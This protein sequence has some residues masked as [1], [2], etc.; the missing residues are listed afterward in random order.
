MASDSDNRVLLTGATGFIGQAV[1][2]LLLAQGA[3]VLALTTDP[4][5]VRDRWG[6]ES[7]DVIN[8]TESA[9]RE[10]VGLFRP[11]ILVHLAWSALP[12][13]SPLACLRNVESTA[14]VIRT[15]L[16]SGVSRFLGA[17]SCWE[18][19]DRTGRLEE[20]MAT[21]PTTM[22][23]QA[24]AC[25]RELMAT[26]ASDTGTE[27]RWGRIFY[28]YGTGQRKTSL[29]PMTIRAWQEGAAPELR[30]TQSAIDLI[31][32][33]DVASGLVAMALQ[34]GPSGTF[35]LGSGHAT[36]VADVVEIVS[37]IVSGEELTPSLTASTDKEASWADISKMN[38]AFGW[39]P[40]ITLSDG[41]RM[42]LDEGAKR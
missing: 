7:V 4:K 17:G 36:R 26:T 23:A 31:H 11:S 22:F 24:K 13:Y 34:D 37:A 1:V 12:D 9:M 27:A 42:M 10:K 38:D 28:A 19:G 29:V 16:E 30:D 21:T 40:A 14:R 41:V 33:D 3:E 5:R 39:Q 15:A 25:I 20:S 6:V 35:N 32:V 8:E 2:S 18:Y